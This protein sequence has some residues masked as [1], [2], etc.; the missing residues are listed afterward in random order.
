MASNYV[1]SSI[2]EPLNACDL[3]KFKQRCSLIIVTSTFGTGGPPANAKTFVDQLTDF[4]GDLSHVQ[5]YIFGLGSSAYANFNACALEIASHLKRCKANVCLEASGDE[6]K[7]MKRSFKAFFGDLTSAHGLTVPE[8]SRFEVTIESSSTPFT[9]P[10]TDYRVA[11]GTMLAPL[12]LLNTPDRKTINYRLSLPKGHSYREGDHLAILPQNAPNM[13][14]DV[15]RTLSKVDALHYVKVSNE[16]APAYLRGGL[17]FHDI[18]RDYVDLSAP[19]PFA[20]TKLAMQYASPGSDAKIQLQFY[21][22][23]TLA[24]TKWLDESNTSVGEFIIEFATVVS[25]IPLDELLLLCPRIS[26]RLYSISSSN[27]D[28]PA[29]VEITVRQAQIGDHL[30]LCSAYLANVKPGANVRMYV[31]PCPAFRLDKSVPTIMIAN[32]TGIAPFRSFW[33]AAPSKQPSTGWTRWINSKTS[34]G[35]PQRVLYYGCRDASELL[36]EKEIKT[37]VDHLAVAF[38]RSPSHPKQYVQDALRGDASRL[39]ALIQSG[40]KVYVCGSQAMAS[41][42]KETIDNLFPY[43]LPSLIKTGKYVEDIF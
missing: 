12:M 2:C 29:R 22:L 30:G 28:V 14:Q 36:Y 3:T 13:V 40:A 34:S 26:P 27:K 7:D 1:P 11:Q 17:T 24:H 9:A 5:A 16:F 38:S 23:S 8:H 21:S 41:E 18:I 32:G 42:V 39:R 20:L 37:S 31:S 19:V 10:P 33:R 43:L 35:S 15:L 25:R 4:Q 6:T